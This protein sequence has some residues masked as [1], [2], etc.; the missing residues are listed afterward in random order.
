VQITQRSRSA[1]SRQAAMDAFAPATHYRTRPMTVERPEPE[2]QPWVD[3]RDGMGRRSKYHTGAMRA[4]RGGR[5]LAIGRPADLRRRR[6]PLVER[7]RRLT[8]TLA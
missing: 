4:D 7:C 3:F 2:P 5:R 1:D 6:A 8:P